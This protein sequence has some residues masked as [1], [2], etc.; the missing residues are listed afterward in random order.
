MCWSCQGITIYYVKFYYIITNGFFGE[1]PKPY[2]KLYNIRGENTPR[3]NTF[4]DM[5]KSIIA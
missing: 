1:N 5:Y 4:K 3:C 2:F